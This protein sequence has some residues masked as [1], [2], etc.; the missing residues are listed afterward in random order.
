M[1]CLCRPSRTISIRIVLLDETDFLHEVKVSRYEPI[2][3]I[4][5]HFDFRHLFCAGPLADQ[6]S[7]QM[8][9]L[10][11]LCELKTDLQT[12]TENEK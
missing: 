10:A 11:F 9:W 6:K 7:N 3:L 1:N 2:K 8:N 12:D 5:F 4:Y